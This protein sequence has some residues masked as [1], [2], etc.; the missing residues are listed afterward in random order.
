MICRQTQ[1][2]DFTAASS[3]PTLLVYGTLVSMHVLL[4]SPLSKS[5]LPAGDVL[6][7]SSW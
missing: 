2:S 6:V 4:Q 3:S 5:N 1:V 7:S